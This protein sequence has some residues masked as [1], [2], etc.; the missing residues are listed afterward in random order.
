MRALCFLAFATLSAASRTAEAADVESIEVDY[1]AHVSCPDTS[2][3]VS[4]IERRTTLFQRAPQEQKNVR[5]FEI[6]IEAVADSFAG[7]LRVRSPTGEESSR[8]IEARTCDE[9]AD[10]LAYIAAVTVDPAASESPTPTAPPT[11]TATA[12]STTPSTSTSTA[13]SAA[14][15]PSTATGARS[16]RPAGHGGFARAS[17]A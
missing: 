12:P 17:C 4:S 2:R 1:R 13:R 14:T 11:S 7:R 10:A 3:F 15:A 16:R 6:V 5:R 9:V 8:T